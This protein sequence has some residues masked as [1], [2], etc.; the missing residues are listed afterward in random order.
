MIDSYLSGRPKQTILP[1]L[2]DKNLIKN[3]PK[4]K[5]NINKS[6]SNKSEINK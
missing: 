5:L 4:H 3:N 2:N 6:Q 1:K